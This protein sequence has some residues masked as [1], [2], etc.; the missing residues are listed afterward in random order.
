MIAPHPLTV[1]GVVGGVAGFWLGEPLISVFGFC[2]AVNQMLI[3]GPTVKH[4][5]EIDCRPAPPLPDFDETEIWRT[6]PAPKAEAA[7]NRVWLL[8]IGGFSGAA[9]TALGFVLARI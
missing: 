4:R 5:I 9:V 3:E 1:V 7:I 8:L 6:P 2:V